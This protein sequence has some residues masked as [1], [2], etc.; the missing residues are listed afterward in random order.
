MTRETNHRENDLGEL[1]NEVEATTQLVNALRQEILH[2]RSQAAAI[3]LSWSWR[4]TTPLRFLAGAVRHVPG[5]QLLRSRRHRMVVQPFREIIE[6]EGQYRSLGAHSL[7][8]LF[9]SRSQAPNGWV[10]VSLLADS[11]DAAF[12]PVLEV[13]TRSQTSGHVRAKLE[14][15]PGRSTKQLI[16]LPPDVSR[17]GL[18]PG[19]E[20]AS[21]SIKSFQIRECGKLEIALRALVKGLKLVVREPRAIP[22]LF[23]TGALTLKD[24]GAA[25]AA[26]M[27]LKVGIPESDKTSY[28]TWIEQYDTLTDEDREC[29]QR[30]IEQLEFRP[31]ISVLVPVY[32][33]PIELLRRTLDSVL[34]QLYENWELCI[35]DD[36]SKDPAVRELLAE[37][38]QR[39]TRIKVTFRA[40]NGHI[41][42]ASNTALE[43]ATGD[44]IALLDHDDELAEHALYLVAEKLNEFRD[45]DIVFSDEDKMDA[46]GN[47][48]EPYFKTDWN[49]DLLLAQNCVSH[50]GVYRSSRIRQVG[51]FRE[52]YEGSQDWD[53]VLRIADRTTADRIQH[54]PHVLYHWRILKGSVSADISAK[55][56]ALEASRK[57]IR[58]CL[59]R[60][61]ANAFIGPSLIPNYHSVRYRVPTPEPF[62]SI[63]VPTRDH[64]DL[65][66][67][68]TN[69]ILKRTDYSNFELVILDNQSKEPE[70][71]ELLEELRHDPR[72]RVLRYDKSFNYAGINNWGVE[73]A[74]GEVVTLLNN[75]TEVIAEDWLSEMVG[76]ACRKEIGMVGA[77][78]YYPSGQIQQAGIVLGPGGVASHLYTEADGD[79]PGYF[80]RAKLTQNLSAVTAACATF[81]KEVF[82][83]VGGFDE[84]LAVSF[85][86]VDL[87][88]K[89]RERG[90]RIVW[91][92]HAELYHHESVSVGRHDSLERRDLFEHEVETMIKRYGNVL[93]EDPFHNPNLCLELGREYELAFPPRTTKPWKLA[94]SRDTAA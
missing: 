10:V 29:I 47:R 78:L 6:E 4:L 66:A 16:R 8:S 21:F 48:S 2:L 14:V 62:T 89:I 84:D 9:S 45:A 75:D 65:L 70:T 40:E 85:N 76:H 57:A 49:P 68:C 7:L 51:G 35:A 86:D 54:I 26:P 79:T 91:T 30:R 92:P 50:F 93:V 74:R 37:Y 73:A 23:R 53:L 46:E 56:Y 80:G 63:I 17:L 59:A 58:S 34:G 81:R 39:H 5:Y 69:G 19:I 25:S 87:C 33:P 27:L 31:R 52:G 72:V 13:D 44:F 90:Y 20:P 67:P 55:P 32:D 60:R 11:K 88:I 83:E 22:R 77:K 41:S 24:D 1:K 82:L 36:A 12:R 15:S 38:E 18:Q 61:G 42:A 3:E 43:L 28:Q 94:N 71:L 64:A